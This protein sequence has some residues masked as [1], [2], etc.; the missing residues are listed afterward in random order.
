MLLWDGSLSRLVIAAWITVKT[1]SSETRELIF[2]TTAVVAGQILSH[3]L[4]NENHVSRNYYGF[5]CERRL[6]FAL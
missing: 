2:T 4:G 6:Y 3:G 5:L 1:S